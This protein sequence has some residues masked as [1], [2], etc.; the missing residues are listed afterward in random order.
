MYCQYLL[1]SQFPLHVVHCNVQGTPLFLQTHLKVLHCVL[2][3]HRLKTANSS[4]I[5]LSAVQTGFQPLS[6]DCQPQEDGDGGLWSQSRAVPHTCPAWY[7]DLSAFCCKD[8]DDGG[9]NWTSLFLFENRSLRTI[10]AFLVSDVWSYR[11]QTKASSN[12]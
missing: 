11:R 9:M 3:P 2:Q 12:W 6:V 5:K 7:T 10:A 4:Q 1:F 8:D